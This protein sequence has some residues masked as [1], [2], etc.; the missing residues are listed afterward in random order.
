MHYE[1]FMIAL[2]IHHHALW[3]HYECI[4]IALWMHYECSMN[5]VWMHYEGWLLVPTS[6]PAF[7]ILLRSC[8]FWCHAVPPQHAKRQTG[9]VVF[10]LVA[11][12][13]C[14]YQCFP[15]NFVWFW[16]GSDGFSIG[17][18][19]VLVVSFYFWVTFGTDFLGR[20]WNIVAI[21]CI[22]VPR[23]ASAKCKTADRP[24]RFCLW[25]CFAWITNDFPAF[26]CGS[27]RV[28]VDFL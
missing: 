11:V 18:H 6:L 24:G 25:Q 26:P 16:K 7:G 1:C 19:P 27:G 20:I 12:F 28:P 2:W 5:A 23:G 22:L 4:M 13:C 21:S 9:L 17:S 14:N 10:L 15:Y 8:P 3:M